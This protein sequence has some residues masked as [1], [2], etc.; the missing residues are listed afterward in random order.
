MPPL[1]L[2]PY[3]WGK[4]L[5]LRDRGPTE[6]GGFGVSGREDLL[7]VEDICLVRQQCSPVTVMF[8]D[9]AVAD[10]FDAQVDLGR[11]PAEFGRIWVHTHPGSSPVPS[12]TDE[13]TFERCFGDADWALMLI[14]A[15]GG[16]TYARLRLG[17]DPVAQIQVP[18]ELDFGEPFPAADHEAWSREFEQQVRFDLATCTAGHEPALWSREPR[19]NDWDEPWWAEPLPSLLA[20]LAQEVA[21]G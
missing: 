19:L 3:A 18:V 15:C 8:D 5:F 4:L 17:I 12:G 21:H 11:T 1:R 14:L 16:R 9:D 13:A 2:T 7:L 20:G 10:Y 6:V